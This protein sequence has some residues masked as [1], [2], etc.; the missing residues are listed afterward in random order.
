MDQQICAMY[1]DL[2]G[3]WKAVRSLCNPSEAQIVSSAYIDLSR[4][5]ETRADRAKVER[6]RTGEAKHNPRVVEKG[7]I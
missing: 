7:A 2:H 3:P 1:P 6:A 4:T 5:N